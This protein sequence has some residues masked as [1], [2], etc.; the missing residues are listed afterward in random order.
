MFEHEI[1]AAAHSADLLREAAAYRAVR[2][3]R[4][5][6]RTAPRGQ[7]PRERVTAHGRRTGRTAPRPA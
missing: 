3:A 5:A 6:R 4:A 7:E 1:T 2:E